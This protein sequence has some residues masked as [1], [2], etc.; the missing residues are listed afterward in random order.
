MA[1]VV[2]FDPVNL[3]IVEI[4]SALAVNT[5][6]AK[7]IYSEWKA[8]LLADPSRLGYP[9]AFTPVGGDPTIGS[10][11][12]GVTLFLENRWKIRPAEYS[13]KLIVDG[14]LFDRDGG[15]IFATTLGAY[16]VH[17]ETKVSNL[18]DRISAGS[19]LTSGEST[20][21]LEMY[22][23]LGLDPTRP[24]IVTSTT[25]EAGGEIEQSISESPPGTVTVTRT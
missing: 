1:D 6:S 7:E 15:S 23:L 25:R 19:G 14:N 10:D 3:R 13:H 16:N 18:I 20:M 17:T 5:L 4:N 9:A 11:A 22:R 24:L 12:L 8:W 2:T 21:L